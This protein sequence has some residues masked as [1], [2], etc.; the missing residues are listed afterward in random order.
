MP[1]ALYID[2][3]INFDEIINQLAAISIIRTGGLHP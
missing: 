3:I 1:R 2:E